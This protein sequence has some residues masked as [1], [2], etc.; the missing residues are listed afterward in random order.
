ME[1]AAQRR[2]SLPYGKPSQI[3]NSIIFHAL[4]VDDVMLTKDVR[5]M[6][7]ENPRI[8]SLPVV[9]YSS[10]K[11]IGLINRSIFFSSLSR[12]F[13]IEIYTERSCLVFMD[14]DPLVIEEGTPLEELSILIASRNEKVVADGYIVVSD[15]Q[16]IGT[17]YTQDVLRVMAE[18]HLERAHRLARHSENL[19]EIVLHRTRALSAA[20]EAA[21]AAGRAK[22]SFLANM[23]HEIR[24]PMNAILGMTYLIKRDGL[25]GKQL[26]RLHKV[27]H[28]A[29]HLLTIIN[30]ILDLSKI[31]S[32]NMA[33]VSLPIDLHAIIHAVVE[34]TGSLAEAK[35]IALRLDCAEI[36]Q[37][38]F[39]GD[40]TRITQGLIDYMQQCDQ[41]Y[42]TRERDHSL[43]SG[44]DKSSERADTI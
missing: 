42:R 10:K 35:G 36:P 17:G 18:I 26:E 9:E 3:C 39:L 34:M 30:D 25:E 16:Y 21:E 28:A 23:S 11:P 12:P 15:G 6:F 14:K 13:F 33:L 8:L 37:R 2:A 38:D 44:G 29:N 5:R 20:K 43:L 40:A 19:E 4:A 32:G 27:E 41:V 22:S 24:T 31:G 1:L 7:E